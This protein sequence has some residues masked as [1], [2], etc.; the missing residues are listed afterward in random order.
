VPPDPLPE[1]AEL[2]QPTPAIPTAHCLNARSLLAAAGISCPP[3][4][5]QLLGRYFD[6]FLGSGFLL[7]AAAHVTRI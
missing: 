3:I 5:D 7:P 1:S 4:D 6:F 2:P